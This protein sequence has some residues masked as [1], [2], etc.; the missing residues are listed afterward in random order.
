MTAYQ[1]DLEGSSDQSVFSKD[2]IT[3]EHKDVIETVIS[4]LAQDQSAM[5]THNDANYFWKFKYGTV[6]VFVQLTGASEED[7]FTVWSSILKLPANNEP[8]MMRKLLEMNWSET[9]EARF[10]I[11]EDQ[12]VVL[13]TR[14]VAELSPGEVSR[15][16]TVVATIADDHDEVL[17]AEYGAQ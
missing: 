2:I 4:S 13:S 8:Q 1:S 17:Q 15:I 11:L 10:G 6:E 16:I 14:T 3:A 5:V 12:I 9:F 7:T